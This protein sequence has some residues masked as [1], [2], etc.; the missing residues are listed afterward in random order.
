MR[1]SPRRSTTSAGRCC[2]APHPTRIT[3]G[4]ATA[5]PAQC[6][7]FNLHLKHPGRAGKAIKRLKLTIPIEVETPEP[8]RLAIRLD[9]AMDKT[10]RHGP[11]AIEVLGVGFD[12][13][14]HQRVKLKLTAGGATADRLAIDRVG[15]LAPA[16]AAGQPTPPAVSPNVIQVLDQQGRQF[17]WY[18]ESLKADG[19]EVTAELMMWPEGGIAIP[20]P[21]GRGVVPGAD[22]ATAVPTVL[23][24]TGVARGVVPA[25]FEFHD[26][27]LP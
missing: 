22:R 27:P 1:S 4:S 9:N 14:G 2:P 7:S 17:P 16:A 25:T 8:D 24:H 26:V 3:P 19:P 23:F 15:N 20:V 18:V 10:V 13:Q 12:S 21:A 5:R 6:S 11:T